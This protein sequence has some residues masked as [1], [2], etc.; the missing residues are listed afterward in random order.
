M[1]S[2][3]EYGARVGG[4]RILREFERRRLPLTVFAVAMAMQRHPEFTQ[5]CIEQGHEIACHGWRWIHYQNIPEDIER[6]HLER[7]VAIQRALTGEEIGTVV[8]AA[9]PRN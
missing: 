1:E 8:C 2:I 7:A 9:T 4:W 6:E 5:A 3:Y